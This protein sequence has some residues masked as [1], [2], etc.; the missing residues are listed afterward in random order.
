MHKNFKTI[1]A[2][3]QTIKNILFQMQSI[4]CKRS[5]DMY[6]QILTNMDFSQCHSF[7]IL[8]VHE[9]IDRKILQFLLLECF[10]TCWNVQKKEK[11]IEAPLKLEYKN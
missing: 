3:L 8:I 11:I 6:G 9:Q 5:I 1:L 2:N 10:I 7:M 4:T